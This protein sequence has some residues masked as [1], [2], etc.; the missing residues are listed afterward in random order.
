MRPLSVI[1]LGFWPYFLLD[2]WPHT[3]AISLDRIDLL[4]SESCACLSA[5]AY[6]SRLNAL[7]SRPIRFTK[8]W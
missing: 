8:G 3:A 7:V 2:H 4:G 5:H 1:L 6:G